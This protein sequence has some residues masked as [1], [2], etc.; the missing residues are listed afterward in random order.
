MIEGLQSTRRSRVLVA[1]DTESV[2]SLFERLLSSDGHDVVSATDGRGALD[3]IQRER[4]DVILLD[5]EMPGMDGLEVCRRLKA[6]PATRLT[7]VVMVTG[8]TDLSDRIRGI[9][10]VGDRSAREENVGEVGRVEPVDAAVAGDIAAPERR[11]GAGDGREYEGEG[12]SER[13]SES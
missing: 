11:L 8:Q 9:E 2:R 4:P 12:E 1:D 7:P 3:A 10:A 13:E 6:D 5:V